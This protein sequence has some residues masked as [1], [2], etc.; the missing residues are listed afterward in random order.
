MNCKKFTIISFLIVT[1]KCQTIFDSVFSFLNYGG[2][3]LNL[4]FQDEFNL[5]KS[6]DF[7]IVGAGSAG[8]ALANRLSEN[9]NWNILLIEAGG[10]ENLLMDVPMFVHYLQGYDVNWKYKT[11]R[12]EN[13]CLAMENNQCHWPRGKVMGGSSVLNYMIYTRGHPTDYDKWEK[14]GNKGWNFK[15]VS[16]YF[17][18]LENNIAENLTPNYHGKNGPVTVSNVDFKSKASRAFIKA[19]I[20]QGFPFSDYNG[21]KPIGFSFLQA[22]I[23]NATRQS[24]NVAYLYPISQRKNL[25]VKKLSMVTK[26]LIDEKKKVYGVQ[27]IS[28]GKVYSI[29]ATKEVILSAGAINTPQILMLS[30]IG[31]KNHLNQLG[32]KTVAHLAVGYNLMDHTAPGALTFRSNTSSINLHEVLRLQTF[33]DYVASRTGPITSAGGIEALAFFNTENLKDYSG[34]PDMELMFA[35]ASVNIDPVFKRNFALKDQVYDDILSAISAE[36]KSFMIMPMLLRPKSQGRIKLRSRNPFD[37]PAIHANYFSDN[38]NYDIRTSTKA[39]R[40]VKELENTNSFKRIGAKLVKIPLKN[41]DRF[42]YNSDEYWECF[43]RHFSFT[44]YHYCG[45]A[46]MGPSSD[47]KAVVDATLKVH[48]IKRLRVVDASVIPVMVSGHTNAP[49]I[50]IAEKAADMIKN[51]WRS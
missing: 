24:T 35:G 44:I 30:G 29:R 6:Y 46:K 41:C 33:T 25:H 49:T 17:R 20:E 36:E 50:M 40:F 42:K 16:H 1:I 15:N 22:T 26:L 4:E 32:I 2:R 28:N 5:R 18:K 23:A 21:P 19:G 13:Y 12:S 10:N 39:I 34:I 8:C 37:K 7:I 48:G 14:M 27:F 51:E 38:E 11:E 45:T 43:M 47:P 3:Q 9:P 31:P